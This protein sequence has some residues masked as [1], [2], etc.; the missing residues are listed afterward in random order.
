MDQ[1]SNNRRCG[2]KPAGNVS[3]SY[4]VDFEYYRADYHADNEPAEASGS[5]QDSFAL[6]QCC[7][8]GTLI[9]CDHCLCF[10][11]TALCLASPLNPRK[12][13]YS[14]CFS[15][16]SIRTNPLVSRLYLQREALKDERGT[17]I[18]QNRQPAL[19]HFTARDLRLSDAVQ[20][21]NS[22]WRQV[23]LRR[24]NHRLP[25]SAHFWCSVFFLRCSNASQ[26]H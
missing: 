16:V 24:D 15:L 5:G 10:A 3:N 2:A 9:T 1:E 14:L 26:P 21:R 8:P 13:A 6:R 19:R 23:S 12:R 20:L 18:H 25:N 7:P 22:I 4:I 11:I 17:P